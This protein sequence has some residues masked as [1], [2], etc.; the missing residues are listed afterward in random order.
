MS[1]PASSQWVGPG[2]STNRPRT[3]QNRADRTPPNASETNPTT[4]LREKRRC[5]GAPRVLGRRQ[6]RV[7]RANLVE[8][9]QGARIALEGLPDEFAKRGLDVRLDG[10]SKAQAGKGLD[11]QALVRLQELERLET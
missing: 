5:S 1:L 10:R 7:C 2:S 9:G 11:V 4:A 6:S 3:S 8:E